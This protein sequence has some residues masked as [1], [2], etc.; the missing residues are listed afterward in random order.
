MGEVASNIPCL[1]PMLLG[2]TIGAIGTSLPNAIGSVLMAGQGKSAAAI[3]NAFGSNVQ[4]VFLAMAGPWIIFLCSGPKDKDGNP[5]TTVAMNPPKSGQ[6][7]QE[8]VTW[9]IG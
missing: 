5:V 1:T 2:V 8:G 3:G 6:S 7:V 4:N 9:M